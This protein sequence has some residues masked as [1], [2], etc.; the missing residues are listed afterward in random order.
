MKA[1]LYS[2]N[3]RIK[4]TTY[5]AAEKKEFGDWEY[6]Y[7]SED[8]SYFMQIRNNKSGFIR[9]SE[10]NKNIVHKFD[11]SSPKKEI[12]FTHSNEFIPTDEIEINKIIVEKIT[13]SKY[14][15]KCYP[16]ENSRRPNLELTLNLKPIHINLIRLYHLDL[17]NNIHQKILNSLAKKLGNN[18]NYIIEDYIVNY[19]NG[20]KWHYKLDKFENINLKIIVPTK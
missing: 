1:Q 20:I 16:K 19:K 10:E 15:I 14:S 17:S 2:F 18:S 4:I 8:S 5:K 7:N 3:Y 11:Y 12:E 9:V 6:Y 13:D